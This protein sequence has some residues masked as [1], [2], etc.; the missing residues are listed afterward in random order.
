MRFTRRVH[1][2]MF[3]ITP[4]SM[5]PMY[6][7]TQQEPVSCQR[8]TIHRLGFCAQEHST[9]CVLSMLLLR[10]C[11]VECSEKLIRRQSIIQ[12]RPN[13]DFVRGFLVAIYFFSDVTSLYS[14]R[15]NLE[16]AGFISVLSRMERALHK[17]DGATCVVPN[18]DSFLS[19]SVEHR[20]T[21][22]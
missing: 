4:T 20:A 16:A 14:Y 21:K 13:R 5:F 11:E 22:K 6:R 3:Q 2:S 19:K 10:V 17:L 12:R 1:R 15:E 18:C 7:S 8:R 9:D